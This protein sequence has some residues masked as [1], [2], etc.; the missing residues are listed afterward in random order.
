M[1]PDP[2]TNVGPHTTPKPYLYMTVKGKDKDI[3]V[4]GR[5]GP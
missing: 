5:G 4:T 1:K 3:P 2:D